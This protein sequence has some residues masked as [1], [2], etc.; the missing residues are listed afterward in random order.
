ME[1]AKQDLDA[2]IQKFNSLTEAERT[3]M[4]FDPSLLSSG[5][6]TYGQVIDQVKQDLEFINNANAHPELNLDTSNAQAELESLLQ[7]IMGNEQMQMALGLTAETTDALTEQILNGEYKTTAQVDVE[8]NA[9]G[10]QVEM[11]A[12][13]KADELK[14]ALLEI[15][16]AADT[17][18]TKNI[19]TLGAEQ[20]VPALQD[21]AGA[22]KELADSLGDG[23]TM[24]IKAELDTS[25]IDSKL[26]QQTE[27]VV[28]VRAEVSL[29]TAEGSMEAVA[30]SVKLIGTAVDGVAGKSIGTLGAPAAVSALQQVLAMLASIN[31]YSVTASVNVSTNVNSVVA[32][33]RSKIAALK[34]SFADGTTGAPGG[35]SLVGELGRELVV[36]NGRYYTVGERGAEFVNLRRGDIVFNHEDT[37]RIFAGRGGARGTALAEGNAYA[38]TVSSI[39]NV[40]SNTVT[41]ISGSFNNSKYGSSSSSSSKKKSSSKSRNSSK[42]KNV[43]DA[44]VSIDADTAALE[45][46]LKDQLDKAEDEL[47]RFLKDLEHKVFLLQHDTPI[48]GHVDEI[49]DKYVQMQDKLHEQAE[50]YRAMGLKEDSKYLINLSEKWYDY[51]D[52]VVKAIKEAYDATI[53]EIDNSSSMNKIW[54][55]NAFKDIPKKAEKYTPKFTN[56]VAGYRQLQQEMRELSLSPSETIFGNIDTNN[57]Q[58]LSW[59]EDN[60]DRFRS[61]FESWGNVIDDYAGSFSTVHGMSGYFGDDKNGFEVAFTP[62][63]N[64]ENGPEYLD[65]NTVYN[66]INKLLTEESKMRGASD[67]VNFD[68]I[69]ELDT[70]GL[71]MDGR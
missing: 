59:T 14:N 70:S 30:N 66:Y 61:A 49:V 60:I 47:D 44:T 69:F 54:M 22:A 42:S 27:H 63:L 39:K 5:F 10:E 29:G 48:L 2:I 36:S 53:T 45:K 12:A 50:K 20:A 37:E 35:R 65:K 67:P 55:E 51:R 19:G 26:S 34:N 6:A 9:D 11:D 15:A 18:S 71:M 57:R 56:V 7:L 43:G 21:A 41:S 3:A 23:S 16:S 25:D 28:Q 17:V 64:T 13:A 40:L 52:K 38:G 1:Q 8:M 33:V 24:Q 58:V 31:G 68:K 46:Q 62:I 32:S 4:G